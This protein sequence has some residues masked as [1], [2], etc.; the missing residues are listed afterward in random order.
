MSKWC[1]A[2]FRGY[3]QGFEGKVSVC[4]QIP[5]LVD[6]IDDP[7]IEKLRQSFLNGEMP[8][9]C[10]QG[11]TDKIREDT[12]RLCGGG[13][14]EE[15]KPVFLDLLWSNKCNFACMGC[16][17]HL[18][19]TLVDKYQTATNISEPHKD[20]NRN[21][22]WTADFDINWILDNSDTI[23]NIHLNGG[24]P[25]IQ[26]GFYDL[27]NGLIERN[28]THIRIWSHTNGSI[29][30]YKGRDIV[31]LLRQFHKPKIIMSH[32]GHGE[33][34]EY[35]RW[36]L[37]SEKWLASLKRFTEAGIKVGVQF[38]YNVFNAL[39][40][41]EIADYYEEHNVLASMSVWDTP[42]CYSAQ[43]LRTS[44]DLFQKAIQLL[45]IHKGRYEAMDYTAEYMKQEPDDL[46]TLKMQFCESIT[47]WDRLRNTDFNDTFPELSSL[48][49]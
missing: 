22:R 23:T 38:S 36:G 20:K 4:C 45:D 30:K 3:Y 13:T 37:N 18:S 31:D 11:C 8:K 29:S 41:G 43:Y 44:E 15:Y 6:S 33:Q 49:Y 46:N 34:G 25:F 39:K 32:E 48:Y 2:P 19:S 24:E 35:I 47:E 7:A 17:P 10:E 9:E 40:I 1:L 14:A 27:L 42:R 28:A 16:T 12:T 5:V 21:V 26:E